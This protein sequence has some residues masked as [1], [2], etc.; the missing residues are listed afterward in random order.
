ML[1]VLGIGPAETLQK[2]DIP[3]LANRSGVGQNMWVRLKSFELASGAHHSG[4]R[5]HESSHE[6]PQRLFHRET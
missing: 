2:F 3:V 6:P 4:F 1:M 5:Q